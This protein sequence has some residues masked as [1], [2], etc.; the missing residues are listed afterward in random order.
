MTKKKCTFNRTND[1]IEWAQWSW[2]PVTGCSLGCTYCYARDIANRFYPQGFEPTFH[3]ERLSAPANTKPRPGPGGNSVFV[4]SM[5][6]LFADWIID[7]WIMP[8]IDTCM[9]HP[10]WTF[11][12]LTKNPKRLRNIV[13][14]AN[15]WVGV[16]VDTQ[17]R[18]IEAATYLPDA[19]A[20]VK[21]LSCEPLLEPI[22]F[23]DL[24]FVNWVII[25]G[26]SKTTRA[27]AFQPEWGWVSDLT[28]QAYTSGCR[29]Y[30]KPNLIVR[31][32]EYPE[33]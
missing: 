22:H 31:P 4:C 11:L 1:N 33:N 3:P 30:W 7:G 6:D 19:S 16:T 24:S 20:T 15:C 26:Q 27:P 9:K 14:P 18:A 12:F 2:N 5:S 21:F 25:G 17:A 23:D 28:T 10:E 13:F 29:V 8:V 32:R